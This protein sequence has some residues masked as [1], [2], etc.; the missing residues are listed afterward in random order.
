VAAVRLIAWVAGLALWLAAAQADA[1]TLHYCGFHQVCRDMRAWTGGHVVVLTMPDEVLDQAVMAR[2]V[3]DYDKGWAIY[4]R[5]VGYKPRAKPCCTFDGKTSIVQSPDPDRIAAARGHIGGNGIELY[6]GHFR[7][8]YDEFSASGRHS[9]IVF[10]EM[11]RNFWRWRPQLGALKAFE[12]GFAIANKFIVMDR[13]GLHGAPF[14]AMSFD[15]LKTS[16]LEETWATY[17]SRPDLTWKD[18]LVDG[19]FPANPDG[20]GANDLAGAIFTQAYR[21]LGDSGYARFFA[22]LSQRPQAATPQ[23]AV[24]NFIAAG[25]VAGQ[26]FT[27]LFQGYGPD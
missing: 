13:A 17:R 8:I 26:D 2:L 10:H 19:R 6:K 9:H 18:V 24:A 3:A 25:R 22:A 7:A 27:D 5:L 14:R 11:G 4:A 16:L 21:R 1:Q 20:W 23:Q 12:V 15:R